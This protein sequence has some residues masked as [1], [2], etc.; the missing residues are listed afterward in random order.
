MAR[1]SNRERTRQ[2]KSRLKNCWDLQR[3]R[4]EVTR[5]LGRRDWK[6]K[7]VTHD[8]AVGDNS[9]SMVWLVGYVELLQWV[10]K[11]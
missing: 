11:R 9:S 8:I 10:T 4:E 1:V 7:R 6:W 5:E 3:C 2:K